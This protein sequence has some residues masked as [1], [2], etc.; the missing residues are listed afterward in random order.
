MDRYSAYSELVRFLTSTPS[1][2][3][4]VNYA[5][6]KDTRLRVRYLLNAKRAGMLTREE[7]A[8]LEEFY[9]AEHFMKELKVRAKR[10]VD[11]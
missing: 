10:K 9:K 4:I 3:D 11:N 7:Q 2:E 5:A 8:E 6:S 1:P